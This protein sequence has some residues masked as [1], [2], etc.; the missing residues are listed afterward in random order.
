MGTSSRSPLVISGR[1]KTK[2]IRKLQEFVKSKEGQRSARF[3]LK[4]ALICLPDGQSKI[5]LYYAFIYGCKLLKYSKE[6]AKYSEEEEIPE[7]FWEGF[8]LKEL[9]RRS[10]EEFYEVAWECIEDHL[11]EDDVDRS[12]VKFSEITFAQAMTEIMIGGADDH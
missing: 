5:P 4:F 9:E 3:C 6:R 7:Y 2:R 10:T 1:R 11:I 8:C 12:L